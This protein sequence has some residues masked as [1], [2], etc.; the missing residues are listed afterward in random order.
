[1]GITIFGIAVSKYLFVFLFVLCSMN[2]L[3][4][5]SFL[6]G[7]EEYKLDE[8]FKILFD[9]YSRTKL[10]KLWGALL[11]GIAYI[12]GIICLIFIKIAWYPAQLIRQFMRF[13]FYNTAEL[14][15]E[16]DL[17]NLKDKE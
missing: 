7:K 17:K 11:F 5:I 15:R 12:G 1:M 6:F 9:V 13:T 10:R 4:F 8:Y 14:Q 3:L 16:Q 2:F